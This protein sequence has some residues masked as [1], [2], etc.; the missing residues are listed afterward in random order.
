MKI[1]GFNT[2]GTY[3]YLVTFTGLNFNSIFCDGRAIYNPS[4]GTVLVVSLWDVDN[5]TLY[6]YTMPLALFRMMVE[7]TAEKTLLPAFKEYYNEMEKK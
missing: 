5:I 3:D 4:T 6:S 7:D 2:M 1:I